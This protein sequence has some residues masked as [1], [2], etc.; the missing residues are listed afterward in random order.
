MGNEP[1]ESDPDDVPETNCIKTVPPEVL[2]LPDLYCLELGGN[3]LESPPYEIAKQGLDAM[4]AHF[5]SL[6]AT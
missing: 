2:Q 4:R 6:Q 5:D 3:P 1:D